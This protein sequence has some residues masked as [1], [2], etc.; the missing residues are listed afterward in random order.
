MT[1]QELESESL[2]IEAEELARA[3]MCRALKACDSLGVRVL[4]YCIDSNLTKDNLYF[5]SDKNTVK[6]MKGKAKLKQYF[7][8]KIG[9]NKK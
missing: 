7:K 4:T 9:E 5:E 1:K 2:R 8:K 6:K 3:Y